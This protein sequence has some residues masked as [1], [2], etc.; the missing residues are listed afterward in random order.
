MTKE[1]LTKFLPKV[2]TCGVVVS[3]L[4]FNLL[5]SRLVEYL[6]IVGDPP[7]VFGAYLADHLLKRELFSVLGCFNVAHGFKSA[8]SF[9]L[10]QL[11][12]D[13]VRRVIATTLLHLRH[14]L[15]FIYKSK[16]V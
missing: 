14:L 10:E 5:T 13:Q 9:R 4:T 11:V 8:L 6:V 7:A 1:G 16:Y 2:A 12:A 15:D 3:A